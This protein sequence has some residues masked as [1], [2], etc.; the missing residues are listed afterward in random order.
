MNAFNVAPESVVL[1]FWAVVLFGLAGGVR[2]VAERIRA[3]QRQA[4]AAPVR[5]SRAAASLQ[6]SPRAVQ[7]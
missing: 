1:M 3:H 6:P 4:A 5:R 2:V 7:G